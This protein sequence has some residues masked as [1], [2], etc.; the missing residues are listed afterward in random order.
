MNTE[1]ALIQ[2][3]AS[4]IIDLLGNIAGLDDR[5]LYISSHAVLAHAVREWRTDARELLSLISGLKTESTMEH[6]A[7]DIRSGSFPRRSDPK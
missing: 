1:H 2:K 4:R 6:I 7:R 3:N 5:N